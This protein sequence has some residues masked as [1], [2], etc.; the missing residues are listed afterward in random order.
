MHKRTRTVTIPNELGLHANAA[1]KI[2]KMAEKAC[3]D[4]FIIKDGHQAVATS[5]L[6]MTSLYCPRGTDV[7]IKIT[8]SGDISI[9]N[10]IVQLIEA[11]FGES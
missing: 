5:I 2:A 4:V 7:T 10:R 1:A 11:G 9:L 6:D 3:S 8:D